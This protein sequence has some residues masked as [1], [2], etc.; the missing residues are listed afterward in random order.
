LK[1]VLE[2]A[3]ALKKEQNIRRQASQKWQKKKKK[4]SLIGSRPHVDVGGY[5]CFC[6][7]FGSFHG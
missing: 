3:T 7:L 1:Q 6:W 5:H 2:K 4:M